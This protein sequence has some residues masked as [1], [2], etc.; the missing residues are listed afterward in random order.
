MHSPRPFTHMDPPSHLVGI[1][2]LERALVGIEVLELQQAHLSKGCNGVMRRLRRN[3]Q[4][5]KVQKAAAIIS[6]AR[7]GRNVCTMQP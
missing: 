2:A 4:L 1:G 7:A 6:T 5:Q 3:H